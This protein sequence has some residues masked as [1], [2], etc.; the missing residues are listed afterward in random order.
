MTKNF[1]ELIDELAKQKFER[2]EF[3]LRS[4]RAW[5]EISDLPNIRENWDKKDKGEDKAM[6]IIDELMDR[7][8]EVAVIT[9]GLDIY[10][11]ARDNGIKAEIKDDEQHNDNEEDFHAS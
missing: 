4:A 1:P 9:Q 3:L 10:R 6:V 2:I 5:T 8:A 11:I 7:I